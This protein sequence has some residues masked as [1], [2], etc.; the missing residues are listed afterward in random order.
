MIRNYLKVAGRALWR[1]KSYA[2]INLLGLAVG[3]ACCLLIAGFVSEE[4]SYDNFHEDAEQIVF[5]GSGGAGERGRPT[6]YPLG[7]VLKSDLP[8]VEE[9]V[10]ILWPGDGEVG[11]DGQ[12]FA[13]EEGVFHV[14]ASFFEV[15]S[16]PLLRG[17]PKAVLQ[18]PNT[19]VVTP[20]FAE[21]H[22]PG[23]DP[24]GKTFYARRYGEHEYR[25]TGVAESREHSYLEFN[26]LLSFSTTDFAESHADS[27]GAYM[28]L[29]FAK[30][31]DGIA[32]EEFEK[33]MGVAAEPHLPEDREP[34]FFA[35]PITGLYLSDL[36]SAEGFRGDWRYVYL[37]GTI[38]AIILLLA[39]INY[40]NLMTARATRRAREVGVRRTVGAGRGQLAGQFLLESVLLTAV[41]FA[42]GLGLARTA[43]PAF[44]AVF[45]LRLAFGEIL[46]LWPLLIAVALGTGLLAGS[47]PALYLSS[48][49]PTAVLRGAAGEGAGGARLRKGLV[50]FQ[51]AIAVALLICT[52]VVYQQ[53]QFAQEKDLGF[54][55]EQVV[56]FEAPSGK[57]E[58]FRREVQSHSSIK[59]A[60]IA[61][62]V[63]GEFDV[64]FGGLSPGD[65]TSAPGTEKEETFRFY[66]AVTD[67]S[68]VETLGLRI[69]AGRDFESNRASDQ[70]EAH[71][72]N[73][74]AARALG[75]T[76]E[77]AVGKPFS[78]NDNPEGR[79]IGVVEDFHTASLREP[80]P[81]VVIQLRPVEGFS[82][83]EEL[84]ARLSGEA[85]GEGLAHIREQWSRMSAD[86]FSY[87]FVS[88]RF[89]EMYETER[90]LGRVFALFAGLAIFV[91]CLG[92]FGL[93]AYAAER[94]RR[95]VAIRKV[96]GA[97]ARSLVALLSRDFLVLVGLA[98]GVA[99][100]AAYVGMRRW[101]EDFAYRIEI[102]PWV[103]AG[104]IAAAALIALL[105]VSSQ[106]LRAAWTDPATAIRQE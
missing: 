90:R 49:R 28:F 72:L 100:P 47:Y 21:K 8:I 3:F 102:G 50:V 16:F 13:E 65:V 97:T 1:E 45:G 91:A 62:S 2:A 56:V 25:I 22:F 39:C 60:T 31:Q 58:A 76:P 46:R 74:T 10:R 66:P 53:L 63:P 75:W 42:L 89:S 87:E 106:A 24:I 37:F 15:F 20:E 94:R 77:E 52:G 19:A 101:L 70:A 86:P 11:A 14:G 36:V 55:G 92:L 23:E 95:E 5:V 104:A 48:F 81:P 32:P 26:A 69:V 64:S 85:I 4:L 17:S 105:A 96:L 9:V 30:L 103:F 59:R 78:L 68:Y 71:L 7:T 98:S 67:T 84:A 99:A 73:E 33:R 18:E 93:A 43:L 38:A 12:S 51:F 82:S 44:N 29:T 6:P 61:G 41:A 80:I 88:Q 27:W 54:E 79:V 57:E 83:G 34:T 35:Q 40:A